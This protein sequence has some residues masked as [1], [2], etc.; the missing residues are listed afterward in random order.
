MGQVVCVLCKLLVESGCDASVVAS[1]L[2]FHPPDPFY[3]IKYNEDSKE[4]S[5]MMGKEL[6]RPEVSFKYPILVDIIDTEWNTKVPLICLKI[7]N[8]KFT[9][10]YSHGNATDLGGM[11]SRYIYIAV[12]LGVNV[13]G[14]D[15]TGYGVSNG[16]P[17]EKQSYKDIEAVYNWCI[18]TKLV[19]S[20]VNELVLYGQSVGS[21]PSCY[22]ATKKSIGALVLHSAILSGIRVLTPSRAL[23]CF[24]IYPNISRIKK[25]KAPV[26][27]IHGE[28]DEEVPVYHGKQLYDLV[29][30]QYKYP[31]YF[32]KDRGH[33]DIWYE[34]EEAFLQQLQKFLEF[35]RGEQSKEKN[36]ND[37]NDSNSNSNSNS[38]SRRAAGDG[39]N[40]KN[41]A[42]YE[43][44]PHVENETHTDQS[45]REQG[46]RG[47]RDMDVQIDAITEPNKQSGN[48]NNNIA[49]S[50]KVGVIIDS[51]ST[52]SIGDQL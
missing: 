27:I 47:L 52:S 49:S 40:V 12:K 8:A 5:F 34:N 26:F 16:N 35:L 41:V 21:G 23:C 36:E 4:Y 10:L 32:V 42:C 7:P 17:T 45:I 22:L 14:Y 2:A 51:E 18:S 50:T 39:V 31:P 1:A 44:I 19:T 30:D 43:V 9:I 38:S 29:N 25:V 37:V 13:V 3:D 24:D 15:Y 20:P 33:N 11:F 6:P 48:N 28:E 46:D